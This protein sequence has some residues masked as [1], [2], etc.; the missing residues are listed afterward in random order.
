MSVEAI[1]SIRTHLRLAFDYPG[2]LRDDEI[3]HNSQLM[4]AALE[5]AE[6]GLPITSFL[7]YV[8]AEAQQA[9]KLA[10]A[11]QL[12]DIA[13]FTQYERLKY[14]NTKQWEDNLLK[15]LRLILPQLKSVASLNQLVEGGWVKRSDAA[16][17][18]SATL[19]H[20]FKLLQNERFWEKVFSDEKPSI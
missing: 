15:E 5:A 9:D 3:H 2:P 13:A 20:L 17:T 10:T 8:Q 14:I 4:A 12:A 11:D 16:F 6:S 18:M 1:T 7:G 19:Y